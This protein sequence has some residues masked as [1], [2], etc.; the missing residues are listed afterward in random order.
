MCTARYL[1]ALTLRCPTP[2]ACT[3]TCKMALLWNIILSFSMLCC[4]YISPRTKASTVTPAPSL[5]GVP[6]K[7]THMDDEPHRPDRVRAGCLF[8]NDPKILTLFFSF[9]L[10]LVQLLCFWHTKSAEIKRQLYL[11]WMSSRWK[12]FALTP[13]NSAITLSVEQP[14]YVSLY[15]IKIY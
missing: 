14:S 10:L 12:T 3:Y 4:R 8:I 11:L 13:F 5:S 9:V 2:L 1:G 6:L 15:S 7:A